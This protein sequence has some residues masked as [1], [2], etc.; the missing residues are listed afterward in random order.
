MAD[1]DDLDSASAAI[2]E[3]DTP[4]ADS[5]AVAGRIEAA[6][7]PDIARGCVHKPGD[8]FQDIESGVAIDGAHIGASLVRPINELRHL[9]YSRHEATSV[10]RF[11]ETARW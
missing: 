10:P 2:A 1:A 5:K 4:V 8:A 3:D 11:S 7:L 6:E 9:P